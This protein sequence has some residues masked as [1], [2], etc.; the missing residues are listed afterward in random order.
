MNYRKDEK[1][2]E[3]QTILE[4][5]KQ[6][7]NLLNQKIEML[8]AMSFSN[9][10]TSHDGAVNISIGENEEALLCQNIPNPFDNS[11]VIPFRIPKNCNDASIVVTE[12]STGRIVTALPISCSETHAV[13][14]AG[15]LSAGNYTYTLYV[16]GKL[17]D[18]KNMVLTKD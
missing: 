18:T 14:E 3:L 11:T 12:T 17:I 8:S 5:Q 2:N 15:K 4:S 6:Q 9:K 1:I 16:D 13:I 7:L 10:Q